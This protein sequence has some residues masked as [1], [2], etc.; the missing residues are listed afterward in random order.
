M[1]WEPGS[2]QAL[3]SAA[4]GYKVESKAG[5]LCSGGRAEDSWAL[6]QLRRGQ[7]P[8]KII[9]PGCILFLTAEAAQGCKLFSFICFLLT[10]VLRQPGAGLAQLVRLVGL[11]AVVPPLLQ[12][13]WVFPVPLLAALTLPSVDPGWGMAGFWSGTSLASAYH[14]APCHTSLA[15]RMW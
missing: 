3:L 9:P 6:P 12:G 10:W 13:S 8:S 7:A 2:H 14:L 1:A 11:H 15:L 5:S 4:G